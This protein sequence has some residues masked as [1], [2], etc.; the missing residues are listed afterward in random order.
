MNPLRRP[1]AQIALVLSA[2]LLAACSTP[3]VYQDEK[4][5]QQTPYFRHVAQGEVE[6]CEAAQRTLLSQGYRL[7]LVYVQNVRAIK[8]FQPDDDNYVTI[9]ISVVCMPNKGGATVYANAVETTYELRKTSGAASLSVPGGG[10]AMPWGKSTDT[11]VK[12]A[13][14]TVADEQFYKRFF[15]LLATQLGK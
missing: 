3:S 12:V 9:D 15:D 2:T 14:K 8:D 13:G 7:E 10:I 4:F 11:L 6:A 5:T 1:L